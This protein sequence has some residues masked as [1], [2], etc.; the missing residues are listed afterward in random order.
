MEDTGAT[1][2]DVTLQNEPS[3]S[4]ASKVQGQSKSPRTRHSII[5]KAKNMDGEC[6]KEKEENDVS[7]MDHSNV[8]EDKE[9][10]EAATDVCP[11]IDVTSESNATVES[12]EASRPIA[13]RGKVARF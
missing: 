9:N 7:N 10:L 5:D 3:T 1:D 2:A 12:T 8:K 11:N 6:S 4:S 13:H